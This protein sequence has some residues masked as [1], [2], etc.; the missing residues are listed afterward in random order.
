MRDSIV[1]ANCGG[2]WG[3]DPG[4]AAR[5]VAGGPVDY[6]VM[7]Y[8][9]EITMALLH[10]ARSRN[11]E[12]GY[13]QDF[14]R[15]LEDVL[16][17]CIE[18]DIRII[19]NAGGINPE[20]CRRDVMALAQR[21]GVADRVE[22][23]VVAGDDILDRLSELREAGEPLEHMDSRLDFSQISDV[24]QSANVYLGANGV[25]RA[26]DLG[27]NVIVSGRVTDTGVTLAPMMHEFGWAPDDYDR[28]AAGIVAGHIIECG[29]Q[30]TGGNFT[31]WR[32][33]PDF[34]AMG[35]PLVEAR[36]DGSFVITKH[37]GSG[38]LVNI[39]TVTE[40]LLY[41]MGN[42]AYLSPDCVARFDSIKL[43]DDG[44]DR[45]HVSGIRGE[46]PPDKLKVSISYANGYRA[47][48]RMLISGPDAVAKAEVAG[49]S[50]WVSAGGRDHYQ[51]TETRLL[52]YNGSHPPLAEYEPSEVILQVAA[53]DADRK[54][55]S[56]DFAPQLVP[57]VLSSVPGITYLAD[58]GRP[59]PSEVV[60]YW[61]CLVSRSQVP[62]R[63]SVAETEDILSNAVAGKSSAVFEPD[64]RAVQLALVGTSI[65]VPLVKLCLARSGDKGDSCNIG[66]IARSPQIYAWMLEN[67][68]EEFVQQ[69][70][71]G[72]CEGGVERYLVA[73]L[74]AVNF[75]LHESLGGGGT[76]SLLPDAQ[77][78][79]YA[80]YLLATTV[81]VD[82]CLL[83]SALPS[84]L[85]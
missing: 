22:V 31:D 36:A 21:L 79:T 2:F 35:Y 78:K 20:G 8:L 70:F 27:A 74:L 23:G 44:P 38:G 39:H 10:K 25:V 6:L 28:I 32:D 53:R 58:Q 45:V 3:D 60:G 65:E 64:N 85:P 77:G 51:H 17:A 55:I 18:K 48:G 49:N 41:E 15:Q 1:I 82:Q 54:K 30:C 29:T 68:T 69:R 73:N 57:K 66:V 4:A 50:F 59:R 14:L 40:Q 63:V 13:A 62:V 42:P 12:A 9:A 47:F 11:P 7:D 19:S 56:A 34:D 81:E 24:V 37:P 33:V 43:T 16:V 26:L 80:Q 72:M 52:G 84:A 61:P 75:L 71:A 67:L 5:Q 83:P 46:A 76:L